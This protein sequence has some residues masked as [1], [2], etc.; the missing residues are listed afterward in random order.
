[1]EPRRARTDLRNHRLRVTL[2]FRYIRGAVGCDQA[3]IASARG[4][5]ARIVD[6]VEN[7]MAE[8]EPHAAGRTQCRAETVLG[9]RCPAGRNAGPAWREV[10]ASIRRQLQHAR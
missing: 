4:V 6:L 1:M 3:E 8:R 10:D 7:A 9:A 5:D 2:F